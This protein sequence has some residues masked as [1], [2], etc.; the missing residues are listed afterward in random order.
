VE[1]VLA[2]R[3]PRQQVVVEQGDQRLLGLGERAAAER[4]RRVQADVRAGLTPSRRKNRWWSGSS[5]R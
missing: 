4:G 2:A 3:R 1:A 5:A